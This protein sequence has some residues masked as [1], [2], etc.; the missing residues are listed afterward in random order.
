MR[1]ITRGLT[2]FAGLLMLAAFASVK[3]W[4]PKELLGS[5]LRLLAAVV[6]AAIWSGLRHRQ[7]ILA[8]RERASGGLM[9]VAIA[10]QLGRQ[11]DATLEQIRAKGG[12][13]G[14]AA[15]LILAERK[16][17]ASRTKG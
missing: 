12:P 8:D 6:I 11:D 17:R 3:T 15:R 10:A 16:A 14:D 2:L 5:L 4:I 13:A 1:L 9:I 7:Q